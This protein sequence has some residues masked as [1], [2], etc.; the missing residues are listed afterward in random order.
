VSCGRW[1]VV[2]AREQDDPEVVVV[3]DDVREAVVPSPRVVLLPRPRREQSVP[4]IVTVPEPFLPPVSPEASAPAVELP[5]N[6]RRVTARTVRTTT[7]TSR[8]AA[9]AFSP[10]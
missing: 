10:P 6:Q 4:R 9:A 7:G 2:P 8:T 5:A 3:A 1:Q